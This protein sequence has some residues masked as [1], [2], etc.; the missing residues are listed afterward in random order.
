[1]VQARSPFLHATLLAAMLVGAWSA[2]AQRNRTPRIPRLGTAAPVVV[3]LVNPGAEPRRLLRLALVRGQRET[4]DMEMGMQ[5]NMRGGPP[6]PAITVRTRSSIEV[7]NVDRNGVVRAEVRADTFEPVSPAELADQLR[8]SFAP[9]VGF[10]AV[11]T[12]DSRGRT[13]STETRMP[14][15]ADASLRSMIDNMAQT[16]SQM[17]SP[18]PDE[19]VGVGAQWTATSGISVGG[20]NVQQTATF[21]LNALE[22]TS[23][24]VTSQVVQTAGRQ[25][26]SLPTLPPGTTATLISMNSN[27]G[28]SQ[29]LALNGLSPDGSVRIT[30][31]TNME[32]SAGG[33]TQPVSMGMEMTVTMHRGPGAAASAPAPAPNRPSTTR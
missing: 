7:K 3:R 30:S 2:A 4:V 5:M 20:A 32:M 15:N 14:P 19:P 18:L 31:E 21:T 16:Y 8:A 12:F 25:P 24:R 22:A 17:V 29:T 1:M 28:G 10:T 26:M 11:I 33:Q 6:M 9:L 27:G 23:I 13:L